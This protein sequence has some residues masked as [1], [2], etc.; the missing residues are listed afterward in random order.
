MVKKVRNRKTVHREV[1]RGLS[2]KKG[3]E[4]GE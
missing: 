1:K 3:G 4:E 2:E